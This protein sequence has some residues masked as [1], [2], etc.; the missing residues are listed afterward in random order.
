MP[1]VYLIH[2]ILNSV[3][4]KIQFFSPFFLLYILENFS[5][6]SI[7]FWSEKNGEYEK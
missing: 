2:M 6:C 3:R 7:W 5:L 1:H 4:K